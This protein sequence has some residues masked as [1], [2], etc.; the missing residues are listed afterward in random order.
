MTLNDTQYNFLVSQLNKI[1]RRLISIEKTIKP[2][3]EDATILQRHTQEIIT[4][5]QEIENLKVEIASLKDEQE[6]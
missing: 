2:I 6:A 3:V 4:V 5:Q 1:D